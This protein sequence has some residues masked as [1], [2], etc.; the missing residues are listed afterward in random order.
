MKHLPIWFMGN[1]PPQ[2]CD[3]ATEEYMCLEARDATMGANGEEL[4]HLN[5]NTTVRF[6]EK[7]HWFGNMMQGYGHRANKE[8]GWGFD[9]TDHE[10]VQF[11]HYGVGQHYGW[12]VD[13][14]P[15]AGLPVD[16]KVSVVCLMSDP[17][18][19]EAGELQIRLYSEYT[20]PLVKGSVIAFPSILEHRV[21][22]VT[23][24]VRKSATLW[25]SGP[26]FK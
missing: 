20:A 8:C 3:L 2:I 18:E 25:L 26:R 22:P 19:F 9:I 17:S 24:G 16:R 21:T 11:A 23:E 4:S 12:H 6:A 5:R 13:N 14:F 1:I 15:L 10:A 7:E